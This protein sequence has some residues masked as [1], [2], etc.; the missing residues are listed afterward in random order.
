MAKKCRIKSESKD[1]V[2]VLISRAEV[3]N[4]KRGWPASHLPD[5]AIWFEF[6]KKNG[7]LVD[8]SPFR[9]RKQREA[10]DGSGALRA[11]SEDAQNCAAAILKLPSLRRE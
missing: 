5:K 6:A 8:Y 7:D 11:L 10:A 9:S 2:T 1:Y 3:E 4:F